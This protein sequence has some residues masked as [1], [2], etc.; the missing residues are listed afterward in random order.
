[1]S[2]LFLNVQTFHPKQFPS[3]SPRGDSTENP[4]QPASGCH[5]YHQKNNFNSSP[6]HEKLRC[7]MYSLSNETVGAGQASKV[8]NVGISMQLFFWILLYLSGN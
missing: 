4:T 8:S 3:C 2:K 6:P 7:K 1:M 5:F